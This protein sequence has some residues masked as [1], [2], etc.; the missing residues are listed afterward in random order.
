MTL[1]AGRSIVIAGVGPGLGRVLAERCSA[2]GADL[3]LVA[4]R[5][6]VIGPLAAALTGGE[7]RAI[8]IQADLADTADCERVAEHALGR[9]G[10]IDGVVLNAF[11][12]PGLGELTSRSAA[13]WTATVMANVVGPLALVAALRGALATAPRASIVTVS[14]ISAREPYANSGIYAATKAALH[15]VTRSLAVELGPEGITANTL[16]PGYI[17]GPGL[18]PFFAAEGERDGTSAAAARTHAE[19]SAALRRFATAGEVADAAVF[20]LSGLASGVTGQTLDV[21]AGQRFD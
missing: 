11:A 14:S 17:E 15:S 16:V 6:D 2:L 10:R 4:R 3:A 9:F 8:A 19:R 20:L 13:D 12:R 18:E 1:L 7:R 5:P 21:N